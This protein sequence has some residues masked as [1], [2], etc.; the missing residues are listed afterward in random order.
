MTPT[1]EQLHAH[2]HDEGQ[3]LG[4]LLGMC[5]AGAFELSVR[6]EDDEVAQRYHDAAHSEFAFEPVAGRV[7]Q[8][9]ADNGLVVLRIR[10]D[11]DLLG[12]NLPRDLV[13][14]VAKGH[15]KTVVR[16][17]YAARREL[18]PQL[19]AYYDEEEQPEIPA[20]VETD[21]DGPL[22][23]FAENPVMAPPHITENG[24]EK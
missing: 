16:A 4:R 10:F 19:S 12:A 21:D 8:L 15:V 18:L 11:D 24:A 20:D 13:Y 22:H 9:A 3:R 1:P 17:A 7:G 23:G 2:Y 6:M 14:P 5:I